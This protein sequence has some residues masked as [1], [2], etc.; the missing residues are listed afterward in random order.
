MQV[1]MERFPSKPRRAHEWRIDDL[2]TTR[3][4]RFR[5]DADDGRVVAARKFEEWRENYAPETS[6]LYGY[7]SVDQFRVVA[8]AYSRAAADM[9]EIVSHLGRRG[10]GLREFFQL[11]QSIDLRS[12]AHPLAT[13][14][15]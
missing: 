6:D 4:I 10:L 9:S 11:R 7:E 13:S 14:S 2:Y 15:R 12:R 5:I 3:E 8:E 1:W